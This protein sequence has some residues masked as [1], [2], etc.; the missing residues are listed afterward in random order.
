MPT[1]VETTEITKRWEREESKVVRPFKSAENYLSDAEFRLYAD[2]S[3]EPRP[4]I[5]VDSIDRERLSP[6][7]QVTAPPKDLEE[8]VGALL[9]DQ[10]LLVS[11]EDRVLKHTTV[12]HSANLAEV[13]S[14]PI[15]LGESALECASWTGATRIHLAVVLSKNRK[16]AVGLAQRAGSWI[17]KKTFTV[18]R[19]RDN[20]NFSLTPVDEDWFKA[21]GLPASTTYF[22]D[23]LGT[24]L[25]QPCDTMPDLVKV[26]I[27]KSL[28]A[29][30]ARDEESPVAKALI[31]SIY[32]DVVTTILTVGFNNLQTGVVP[33]P[34]SIL[35]VVSTRLTKMTGIP[36]AKLIQF[37]K[38]SSGTQL[39]AVLQ[40]EA[41]LTRTMLVAS[42]RRVG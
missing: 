10:T 24:D 3:F 20:A 29:A 18:T 16:A 28:N 22:V 11:I 42:G 40:A 5:Q 33:H 41:E 26:Y 37:A 30:L 19:T 2:A 27:S 35:D 13:V 23:M 9:K 36:G 25:N 31:K 1:A 39:Q 21:K 34:D 17:A 32:V 8:S 12:L 4:V 7:I 14:G 38:D 6:A 15:E